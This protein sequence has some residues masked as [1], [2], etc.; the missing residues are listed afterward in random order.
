LKHLEDADQNSIKNKCTEK[1]RNVQS[2]YT[3]PDPL[4]HPEES[5]KTSKTSNKMANSLNK[6]DLIGKDPEFARMYFNCEVSGVG[7]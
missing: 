6:I 5:S 1:S 7:D 4:W 2:W 3:A